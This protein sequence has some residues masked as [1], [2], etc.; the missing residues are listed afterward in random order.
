MVE[1]KLKLGKSYREAVID[2]WA[3]LGNKISL[4]Y[5]GTDSVATHLTKQE[6]SSFFS[7][8]KESFKSIGR[9]YQSNVNDAFKQNCI[10]FLLGNQEENSRT[11]YFDDNIVAS[12]LHEPKYCTYEELVLYS[13]TWNCNMVDP[14]KLLPRDLDRL[15]N[16]PIDK[17]DLVVVCLQEMVELNSYNVLMGNNSNVVGSWRKKVEKHLNEVGQDH[18]KSFVHLTSHDMVGIATF[19]FVSGTWFNKVYKHEWN[20]VKTGFN[21]SLGNKGTI[22]LFLQIENTYLTI[23]NCHLAA[24]ENASGERLQGLEYI[25]NDA[26]NERSKRRAFDKSEYKFFIGDFNFRLEAK[27]ESVREILYTIEKQDAQKKLT[28]SDM[29]TYLQSLLQ[30]DEYYLNNHSGALATY[31][32]ATIY[33]LPTYKYIKKEKKFDI[34]RTPAWCDRILFSSTDD[35][36]LAVLKY[37]DV[38]C[39]H[40]DHKPVCG[41]FKVLIKR[42]DPDKKKKLLQQYMEQPE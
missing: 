26:L 23:A 19:V 39:Y 9:Y 8:L 1:K 24:G 11:K 13:L 12:V 18:G 38:E 33:F 34:K 42:E 41:A 31:S 37:W 16:F 6:E 5:S 29:Q 22:L 2:I 4:I 21:N 28:K 32:E 35:K 25:H 7:V 10:D 36:K 27:N 3:D 14:E 20:D 15:F 40:S 30:K 17:T